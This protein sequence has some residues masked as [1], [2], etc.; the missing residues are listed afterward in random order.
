[1]TLSSALMRLEKRTKDWKVDALGC[2]N[3]NPGLRTS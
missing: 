2:T 3:M 1:M